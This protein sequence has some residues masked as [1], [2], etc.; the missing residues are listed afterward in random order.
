VEAFALLRITKPI[1]EPWTKS[2]HV[3]FANVGHPGAPPAGLETEI[4][5]KL[6]CFR[7]NPAVSEELGIT[8]NSQSVVSHA[9]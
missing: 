6:A 2:P 3:S 7:I 9:M 1:F 8:G 5:L 4:A